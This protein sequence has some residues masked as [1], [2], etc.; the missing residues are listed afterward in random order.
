MFK[1]LKNRL[2]DKSIYFS[3]DRSGYERHCVTLDH[4]GE[5]IERKTC[6]GRY[7]LI[8]GGTSG[9][10]KYCAQFLSSHQAKVIFTGRNQ[11]RGQ[12][13]VNFNE[14]LKFGRLDMSDWDQIPAFVEGLPKIDFLV[15]NAG[16]MPAEFETN[17]YGVESQFASQLM[18]HY[19]LL[20]ELWQRELLTKTARVV[21]VTSGGMYLKRLTL[22]QITQ[23]DDYNKLAA[24][25][26][27]KRAQVILVEELAKEKRFQGLEINCMHPGWVE[28]PGVKNAIAEFYAKTKGRLRDIKQGADTILWMLLTKNRLGT[29]QLF[30]DRQ[31]Q[32]KYIF[33]WTRESVEL[34]DH[35][36]QEVKN[37]KKKALQRRAFAK[38]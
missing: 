7:A 1:Q 3:F 4:F 16:G 14:N 22:D 21:W 27:T 37:I 18:G 34:R 26:N 38:D 17:S 11:V 31:V 25:A 19:L 9:I 35:F 2:L 6:K 24:Y 30:F 15:L 28:T 5:D 29:G 8:T 23:D 12:E 13:L 33:P 20:E 32:P 10:G 36:L